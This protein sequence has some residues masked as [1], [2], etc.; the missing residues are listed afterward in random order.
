MFSPQNS[1]NKK[2][3]SKYIQV[4][5]LFNILRNLSLHVLMKG[6][7]FWYKPFTYFIPKAQNIT[8]NKIS[9]VLVTTIDI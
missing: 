3:M 6:D 9:V 1:P 8:N 4:L 7:Q 5:P 2:L